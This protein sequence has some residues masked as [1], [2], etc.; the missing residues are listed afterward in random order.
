MFCN[1]NTGVL[2]HNLDPE[3]PC[4][5]SETKVAK[6]IITMR[7]GNASLSGEMSPT[8]HKRRYSIYFSSVNSSVISILVATELN[9]NRMENF[10]QFEPFLKRKLKHL[11]ELYGFV[12]RWYWFSEYRKRS[13]GNSDSVLGMKDYWYFKTIKYLLFDNP[14]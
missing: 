6:V 1:I 14:Q 3:D 7:D 2:S 5:L 13:F 8:I 12:V 4:N 9:L 10:E 11:G